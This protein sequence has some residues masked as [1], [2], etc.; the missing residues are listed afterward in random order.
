MELLFSLCYINK[1]LPE[2][3][4]IDANV[5]LSQDPQNVKAIVALG[6]AYFLLGE[7]ER[8]LSVCEEGLEIDANNEV[9]RDPMFADVLLLAENICMSTEACSI[10]R[11]LRSKIERNCG[12]GPVEIF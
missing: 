3:A 6:R 1:E 5:A 7:T 4:I 8:S 11:Y 9:R 12:P 2:L 10:E